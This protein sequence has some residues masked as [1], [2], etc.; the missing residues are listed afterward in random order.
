MRESL[1][2]VLTIENYFKLTWNQ[3][4][5]PNANYQTDNNGERKYCG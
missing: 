3:I 1:K 5:H 2:I 4:K